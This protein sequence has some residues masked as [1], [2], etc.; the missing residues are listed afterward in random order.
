M[1]FYL[2]MIEDVFSRKI[3]GWEIYD[4][5]CSRY[6]VSGGV[7]TYPIGRF[8]NARQKRVSRHSPEAAIRLQ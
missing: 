6:A 5:E 4:R 7:K 2:Y 3:V 1:F 8:E